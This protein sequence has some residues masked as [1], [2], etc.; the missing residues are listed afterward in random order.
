[1]A[2][3]GVGGGL[4]YVAEDGSGT[5]VER[6]RC[7]D[8]GADGPNIYNHAIN[9]GGPP[10]LDGDRG[11]VLGNSTWTSCVGGDCNESPIFGAGATKAVYYEISGDSIVP[12]TSSPE[13]LNYTAS[14]HSYTAVAGGHMV[15][16]F[17]AWIARLP[18]F[19]R[20]GTTNIGIRAIV[21]FR[22]YLL[23]SQNSQTPAKV[24]KV[25]N[26]ALRD[27]GNV[28]GNPR[29]IISARDYS[30][31]PERLVVYDPKTT[32]NPSARLLTYEA[33][34]SGLQL[35]SERTAPTGF[36]M[37]LPNG[38]GVYGEYIVTS[39]T[40]GLALWNGT[41]KIAT[42][43]T[44]DGAQPFNIVISPSG[45]VAVS[46][47]RNADATRTS[48]NLFRL[49]GITTPEQPPSDGGAGTPDVGLPDIRRFVDAVN[50]YMRFL[51]DVLR[52]T[53]S[54]TTP[55]TETS[56]TSFQKIFQDLNTLLRQGSSLNFGGGGSS[57]GSATDD[58]AGAP[59]RTRPSQLY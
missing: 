41:G 49:V 15:S 58:D 26:G 32:T 35:V 38:F 18:E 47:I 22:D 9:R 53:P 36:P 5:V 27:M 16:A 24:Y 11:F 59:Y 2:G 21:G 50:I 8:G 3:F 19:T 39:D 4:W 46:A 55:S 7:L 45:Y 54:G 40:Q 34:A 12:R 6:Q 44:P 31:S 30:T 23:E 1:M 25:E 57:S 33:T 17:G 28:P 20:L 51:Q 13:D 56:S 42:V 43:S 14:E 10:L 37:L 48:A 29:F 52:V